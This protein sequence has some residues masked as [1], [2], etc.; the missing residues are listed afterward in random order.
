MAT[1]A[2][3]TLIAT[4]HQ[5]LGDALG[6]ES[7]AK[8]RLADEYDAAQKRGEVAGGG[9]PKTVADD[10]GIAT[11]ADLGLTSKEVHEAR[12]IRDAAEGRA[13]HCI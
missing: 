10:N 9:R 1:G 7:A 8:I 4:A 2:H 13:R 11:A 6:I 3:D 12:Q 5:M